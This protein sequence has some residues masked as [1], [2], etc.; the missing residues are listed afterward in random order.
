[1]SGASQAELEGVTGTYMTKD[2]AAGRP[3]EN[4]G[5]TMLAIVDTACTKAV[6][7]H[8]WFEE[9]CE[10]ADAVGFEVEILEETDLF[11]FGA[12]RTHRSSF[13]VRAWFCVGGAMFQTD[14]AVVPCNVPL[15]FSRPIL[16][17]LGMNY[18]IAAQEVSFSQLGLHSLPLETS[19]TGH[20]ALAVAQFGGKRP[21]VEKPPLKQLVW[22]PTASAYMVSG[23][24]G[25][26]GGVE[27]HQVELQAPKTLFYPK[28]VSMAVRA[29]L[30][31]NWDRGGQAFTLWWNQAQQSRDFWVETAT[32]MIRIH[33]VPR[34]DKFDPSKWTTTN[35]SLKQSLLATLGDVRVSECVPCIGQGLVLREDRGP[36]KHN[37]AHGTGPP[38]DRAL[39]LW[40]GRSRFLKA[41]QGGICAPT[42]SKAAPPAHGRAEVSMEDA[43][44]RADHGGTTR[45]RG[46]R[47]RRPDGGR[48]RLVW[49]AGFQGWQRHSSL[50]QGCQ[51]TG[52]GGNPAAQV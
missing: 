33:V 50:R 22:I 8:R 15:L 21:P 2:G 52:A 35:Q 32:E 27:E 47:G 31:G 34:M 5:P 45:L 36:W 39:G 17:A 26:T 13:T 11:K 37:Q 42:N 28:K 10:A 49:G 24:Q 25:S 3:G 4:I 14:I 18:D 20:P 30:E 40:V 19:P 43:Q 12:S 1:M 6:A 48:R 29:M 16:S 23:E 38:V 41:N 7:G 46:R 44:R 51:A 9:Y